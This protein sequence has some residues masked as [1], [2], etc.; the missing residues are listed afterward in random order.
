[1]SFW[2]SREGEEPEYIGNIWGW[3]FSKLGAVIILAALALMAYRWYQVK[4]TPQYQREMQ[5]LPI[6]E[7]HYHHAKDS[8]Q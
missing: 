1:M 5:E 7:T 4:D 3:K 6:N 2:K 8:V